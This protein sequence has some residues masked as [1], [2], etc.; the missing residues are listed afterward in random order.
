[1]FIVYFCF[2]F[3]L[4]ACLNLVAKQSKIQRPTRP[5]GIIHSKKVEGSLH[6]TLKSSKSSLSIIPNTSKSS[7]ST[8]PN[9]KFI[10]LTTSLLL[11]LM[12]ASTIGLLS[13]H[14]EL[15]SLN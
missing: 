8:I 4:L 11:P 6:L 3:L 1:M 12:E 15:V 13:L 5:V 14:S 9:T 2:T 10:H 7:L